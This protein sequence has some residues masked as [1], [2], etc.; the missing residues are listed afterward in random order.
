MKKYLLVLLV[1]CFFMIGKVSANTI[2]SIDMTID[3]D[4]Q[5]TATITETW[6]VD[7][8]D[9]T[10]WY[11]A[12][13]NLG[14][15]ELT[16]FKVSMNGKDLKYKDWNV[17]ESLN[18]KKGY[19]GINKTSNG[20]ELCFGKSDYNKHK[21]VLNYKLS[22]YIINTEDS[23]VIY[24]NLIGPLKN[25]DFKNF[26]VVLSSYYEF[27]DDLE[28]WGYGYKGYA[29][30][31]DG[32]IYASNEG[33]VKDSYVVLL[34]KFPVGTFE[35]DNKK[36]GY[37]TFD[38]VYKA[39]E[40]GT[41]KY[42]YDSDD[43][44]V[45]ATIFAVLIGIGAPILI[46]IASVIGTLKDGYGYI[47]NKKINKKETPMFRDIPCNKDI[48][49]ANALIKLNNFGYKDTNI[50][51]AIILKWIKEKKIILKNETKGVFNKETS[52]IDLTLNQAFEKPIEQRLFNAMYKA[53]KDGIL[54]PNELKKW[55]KNN[56]SEFLGIFTSLTKGEIKRLE[57]ENHIYRR[58]NKEECKKQNV[59]DDVI[60]EDS[61]RL[62]G[63]KKFLK[64]F[65]LMK[66]KQ[67]IEVNIWD[68]YLMF[69]Y[70]FDMA[71]AVAKQFKNL[72]PEIVQ[73]MEANN[74][75][76]QTLYF[77]N[78]I[79]ATSVS[80]A[81]AARSAAESYSSGGGGFSSGGGGGGSFG[82]GGGGS[83]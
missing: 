44:D 1:T 72:Y 6:N 83:R 32:K 76:L 49:Y 28:V 70:L 68:E 62:Y 21:F 36:E 81:S 61:V 35:N 15:S 19:Y 38:D 11:K 63:L 52:T 42:D 27:P 29:Y 39:A 30:V 23:Q 48:Y 10:E 60:Y 8:S 71:E 3:V 4:K 5:G 14:N 77:V 16:D 64:E 7:G 51:G 80:A 22:N 82:G 45:L 74:L 58:K 75:D 34:A 37:N 40:E 33:D 26:S 13:N 59:M 43:N 55:C 65:S 18:E 79:S 24:W 20:L 56:Y 54:E 78:Y 41:F 53:S 66:E 12:M 67:A 69:A 25:V 2:E 31:K 57:A 47:N 50:F 17:N 9:G 73:Q 46:V